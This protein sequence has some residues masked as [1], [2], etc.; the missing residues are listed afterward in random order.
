MVFI[1]HN[2]WWINFNCCT[3]MK[4]SLSKSQFVLALFE[5]GVENMWG[6]SMITISQI[7]LSRLLRNTDC[8]LKKKGSSLKKR[9]WGKGKGTFYYFSNISYDRSYIWKYQAT[10]KYWDFLNLIRI[11]YGRKKLKIGQE[12]K[13]RG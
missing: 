8:K 6:G 3:E 7:K 10:M 5:G 12:W 1:G 13:G 11:A 9:W 4:T 2:L